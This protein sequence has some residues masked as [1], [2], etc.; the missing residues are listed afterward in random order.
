M[1]IFV[2][3]AT[4]AFLRQAADLDYSFT[5]SHTFTPAFDCAVK[6]NLI[7]VTPVDKSYSWP[8]EFSHYLNNQ[9]GQLFAAWCHEQPAGYLAVSRHWNGLALIEDIAVARQWRQQGVAQSLLGRAEEW[10]KE[11]QLAGMMLETQNTNV[12]ACLLYERRGFQL[13]GIDRALYRALP[14]NQHETALW[15]YLFF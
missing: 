8:T 5:V 4:P 1:K 3:E 2:A 11:Q 15:W 10:A 9:R 14:Q 7:P 12:P 13:Q 6:E